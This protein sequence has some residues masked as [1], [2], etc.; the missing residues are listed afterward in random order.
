MSEYNNTKME[1]IVSTEIFGK[2]FFNNKDP[3]KNKRFTIS[4]LNNSVQFT[5]YSADKDGKFKDGERFSVTIPYF[6]HAALSNICKEIMDRLVDINAGKKVEKDNLIIFSG[7][8]LKEARQKIEFN[9]YSAD[10]NSE[11][12]RPFTGYIKLAKRKEA[13][14]KWD[15]RVIWLPTAKVIYRGGENK[16]ATDYDVYAML[17]EIAATSDAIISRSSISR[18]AHLKKYLKQL[19]GNDDSDNKSDYK[20][21]NTSSEDDSFPFD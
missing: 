16:S 11:F 21:K 2:V 5:I 3:E 4:M 20:G 17:Q 10:D 19:Y 12:K 14:D 6:N 18:D 8:S 9:L 13:E 7:R 1:K 15:E